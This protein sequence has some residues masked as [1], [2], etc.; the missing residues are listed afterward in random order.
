V[1]IGAIRGYDTVL[2]D[3]PG[4]LDDT[5]VLAG[6]DFAIVP[7]VPERAAVAPTQRTAR[8]IAAAG[9][10]YR[11]LFNQVDPR[12]A[13]ARRRVPHPYEL[14]A[15]HSGQ[16]GELPNVQ[17]LGALCRFGKVGAEPV[18]RRAVKAV[19]GAVIAACRAR[20]RVG[21]RVLQVTQRA[22]GVQTASRRHA[23]PHAGRDG[24]PGRRAVPP[25]C[26]AA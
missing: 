7:F 17:A 16:P 12:G 4:N 2:L 10:P 18:A 11:V 8:I 26:R 23:A 14:L 15:C 5:P 20:V 3:L 9:L 13:L 25:P 6:S 1:A 21:H 19:A 22:A 24:S